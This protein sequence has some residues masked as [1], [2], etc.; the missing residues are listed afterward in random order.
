M[1]TK[2]QVS[3]SPMARWVNAAAT[4]E[5]TPPL[6][7]QITRSLPTCSRICFT[8]VSTYDCIVQVG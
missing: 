2:I 1:S 7:A 6:K 8:A 4:D 5:S 3:W